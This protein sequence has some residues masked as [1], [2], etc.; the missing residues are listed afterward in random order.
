[1]DNVAFDKV[2][3]L[4]EEQIRRGRSNLVRSSSLI[5]FLDAIKA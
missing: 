5:D 4:T 1:M 2:V 3:N